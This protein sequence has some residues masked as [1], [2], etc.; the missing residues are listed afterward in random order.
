MTSININSSCNNIINNIHINIDIDNQTIC[1]RIKF[2]DIH[3]DTSYSKN[4]NIQTKQSI[5][6]NNNHNNVV[7]N[8][9]ENL[10]TAESSDNECCSSSSNSSGSSESESERSCYEYS[11][12][13][14][15]ENTEDEEENDKVEEE[16]EEKDNIDNHMQWLIGSSSEILVW[17]KE[18]IRESFRHIHTFERMKLTTN[19]R[20]SVMLVEDLREK[21]NKLSSS[22]SSSQSAQSPPLSQPSSPVSIPLALPIPTSTITSTSTSTT[23]AVITPTTTTTTT[24]STTCSSTSTTSTPTSSPSL[25]RHNS[26]LSEK[27]TII[28]N[29][30]INNSLNDICN[31]NIYCNTDLAIIN[32]VGEEF[33]STQ[34][35]ANEQQQE[36]EEEE[37][38]EDE[39]AAAE[40]EERNILDDE[41]KEKLEDITVEIECFDESTIVNNYRQLT[42]STESDSRLIDDN[43]EYHFL[44]FILEYADLN[45]LPKELKMDQLKSILFQ[46]IYALSVAQTEFEFVHN[47]L[48]EKNILLAS[49]PVDKRYVVFHKPDFLN[50][51][52]TK[53]DPPK[54]KYKSSSPEISSSS[55]TKSSHSPNGKHLDDENIS[56]KRKK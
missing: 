2:N 45:S 53:A 6:N 8:N 9:D 35:L 16:E 12:A 21:L 3:R 54:L 30:N 55:S 28:N 38:E 20:T 31:S 41:D 25:Q 11:G 22:S 7:F 14:D 19:K 27:N 18:R 15:S 50:P 13:S 51:D 1:K 48:H 29:I 36:E 39:T 49:L 4:I 52:I 46:I 47:D 17:S 42:S 44:N 5:T 37:E 26:S 10:S 34:P 24:T 33:E 43:N 32:G 56:H 40:E 23:V